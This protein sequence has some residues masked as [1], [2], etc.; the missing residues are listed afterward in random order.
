MPV[1]SSLNIRNVGKA[2][3]HIAS[4][5][6]PPFKFAVL[7]GTG[8]GDSLA[9][10][11]VDGIMDYRDIP[12]FPAST[13]P[14]HYGRLSAGRIAGEHILLF[15]GRF[16]L[17]EGYTPQQ[18]TFPI[19]VMQALGVKVLIMTN[20]A[21][22]LNP[23]F[24]AGDIMII[25]DHINLTGANPLVGPNHDPWGA[26]FPEMIHAYN[27]RLQEIAQSAARQLEVGVQKGTYAGLLGPS[28]ETPAEMR[29]L[30]RVGAEAVGFSTVMESIAAVHAGIQVLALSVIT[31]MCLP[32]APTP[33]SVE[34]IIGVAHRAAPHLETI[35][36]HV[37]DRWG[38]DGDE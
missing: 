32:D 35:I 19:R 5:L 16:H 30:K 34:E 11:R 17:Y 28:L 7:T 15:Q 14:S 8:S 33:S 31:N 21:G 9:S 1:S 29:F 37:I 36:T 24:S 10:L 13:V 20:A 4:I 38:G 22:G 27:W 12:N 23:L 3:E 2:A 26:R 6:E 25:E 18:V